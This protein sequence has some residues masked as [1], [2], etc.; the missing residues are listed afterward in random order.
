MALKPPTHAKGAPPPDRTCHC[1]RST[2]PA[3]A[4]KCAACGEWVEG[5]ADYL[6]AAKALRVVGT[7][8]IAF[9]VLGALGWW[10]VGVTASGDDD[11][12]PFLGYVIAIVVLLQGLLVGLAAIVL[13]EMAPR[14]SSN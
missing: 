10:L 8:W 2:M 12:F 1:C 4:A 5:R 3:R 6:P 14:R 7:I 9:S 13:G 11:P